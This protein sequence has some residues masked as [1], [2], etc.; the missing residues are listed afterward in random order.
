MEPLEQIVS[1]DAG[2]PEA[3]SDPSKIE[4][5]HEAEA[6][7]SDGDGKGLDGGNESDSASTVVGDAGNPQAVSDASTLE[8]PQEVEVGVKEVDVAPIPES[9]GEVVTQAALL[10]VDTAPADENSGV[11]DSDVDGGDAGVEQGLV[12]DV[13]ETGE[14]SLVVPSGEAS[15]VVPSDATDAGFKAGEHGGEVPVGSSVLEDG[16]DTKGDLVDAVVMATGQDGEPCVD[17]DADAMNPQTDDLVSSNF[18]QA[19]DSEGSGSSI[20]SGESIDEGGISVVES[21]EALPANPMLDVIENI[22]K[23]GV[24]HYKDKLFSEALVSFTEAA[25]LLMVHKF[26]TSLSLR[27]VAAMTDEAFLD[28]RLFVTHGLECAEIF[29]KVGKCLVSLKSFALAT[30]FLEQASALWKPVSE[31][32]YLVSLS[33]LAEAAYASGNRVDALRRYEEIVALLQPGS[34]VYAEALAVLSNVQRDLKMFTDALATRVREKKLTKELFGEVSLQFA[35][36]LASTS[37]LH[38]H[39]KQSMEA[40]NLMKRA[41]VILE[42]LWGPHNNLTPTLR[43][44]LWGY[45]QSVEIFSKYDDFFDS[46]PRPA[47]SPVSEPASAEP[48]PPGSPGTRSRDDSELSRASSSDAPPVR[49]I[50]QFFSQR[51]RVNSAPLP[52]KSIFNL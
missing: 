11:T 10:E 34:Q 51:A 13:A 48:T 45:R 2:N 14:P 42:T 37:V 30:D 7:V 19:D 36:S 44:F 24:I 3:A 22:L 25:N 31:E 15:V 38:G 6:T 1:G 41:I 16:T 9:S 8:K 18:F 21:S 50:Q 47:S 32:K 12:S 26:G 39:L 20:G 46:S 27:L 17:E 23:N 28:D 33:A 5:L 29:L 4:R 43:M 35:L 49:G 40:Q 52:R